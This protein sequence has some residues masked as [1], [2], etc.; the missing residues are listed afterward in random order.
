MKNEEKEEDERKDEDNKKKNIASTAAGLAETF[1]KSSATTKAH[2][3]HFLPLALLK[4][5][6]SF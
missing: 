3:R 5:E 4:F 2:F 6:F 1:F